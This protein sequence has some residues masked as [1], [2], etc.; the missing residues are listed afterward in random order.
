MCVYS[1]SK[2]DADLDSYWEDSV[3]IDRRDQR[4]RPTNRPTMSEH[5]FGRRR[6]RRRRE[7]TNK[8][9]SVVRYK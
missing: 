1:S 6:R 8:H 2:A 4:E 7:D 3:G 5:F 9:H